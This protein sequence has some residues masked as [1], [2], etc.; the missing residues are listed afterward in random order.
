MK[1]FLQHGP[2]VAIDFETS[3]YRG[4]CACAIGLTRMENLRVVDSYYTLIRPPS[5]RVYFT[6]IHGLRW[7]DLK[8]ERPFNEVWPEIAKFIADAQYLI[9]HNARF[10]S[11]V[12][13]TC[14]EAYGISAHGK[15]FLCTLR[16]S[17]KGLKL[18]SYSLSS[19]CDHFGIELN[20]HHAGSDATACGLIHS[21]LTELGITTEQMFLPPARQQ[22]A[23][24]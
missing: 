23:A 10:D 8:N 4:P 6:A 17:R 18:P 3:A 2:Y 15:P 22:K 13:A 12:L 19:V 5:S 24:A 21:R 7:S 1:P 20:H 11:N 16:G 14:C 9:A